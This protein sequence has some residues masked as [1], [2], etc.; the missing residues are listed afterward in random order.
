MGMPVDQPGQGPEAGCDHLV[1][2]SPR[3]DPPPIAGVMCDSSTARDTKR[4]SK[5]HVARR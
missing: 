5:M 4:D 1:R 2:V 3:F